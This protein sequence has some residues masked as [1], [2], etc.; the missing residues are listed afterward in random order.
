MNVRHDAS[1]DNVVALVW[2]HRQEFI[3]GPD[4]AFRHR[5]HDSSLVEWP[6][7]SIVSKRYDNHDERAPSGQAKESRDEAELWG[8]AVT[9]GVG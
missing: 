3:S 8:D 9:D 5:V 1:V 2:R 6:T 4:L 7:E